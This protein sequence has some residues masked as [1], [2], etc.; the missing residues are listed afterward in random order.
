MHAA[1]PVLFGFG[2]SAGLAIPDRWASRVDVVEGSPEVDQEDSMWRLPVTGRVPALA[3]AFVRPDGY[4]AWV[5]SA[6]E[7]Y[8][9]K[10]FHEAFD[11]WLG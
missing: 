2:D 1:R 8:S 6:G 10:N 7:P 11:R 4:V 5:G 3:S 9:V